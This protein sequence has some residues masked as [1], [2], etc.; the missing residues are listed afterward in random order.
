MNQQTQLVPTIQINTDLTASEVLR[1]QEA[2]IERGLK[3]FKEA[4][5]ALMR[6]KEQKLYKEYYA[7]YEE[8]CKQRWGFSPQHANRLISAFVLTDKMKSETTGSVVP[9]SERQARVLLRSNDPTKLW[10]E[11]Q[12]KTDKEQPTAKEI[13][14]V[15]KSSKKKEEIIDAEIT[16]T[17]I[18]THQEAVDLLLTVEEILQTPY[19]RGVKTGRPQ[20][21]VDADDDT[22][23]RLDDLKHNLNLPKQDVIAKA[24]LLT[25][26]VLKHLSH[27]KFSKDKK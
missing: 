12:K 16:E 8:Y 26:G 4:G 22:F 27:L 24:L 18:P 3:G 21:S 14:A 19:E 10:E 6:I 20:V 9:E 5:M 15:M 13:E 25:E 7:T 2:I 23:K 11:A 17:P 1:Q